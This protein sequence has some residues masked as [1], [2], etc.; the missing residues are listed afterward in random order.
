M[1]ILA[2]LLSLFSILYTRCTA[3]KVVRCCRARS[4]ALVVSFVSQIDKVTASQ[5]IVPSSSMPICGV[6]YLTY[7]RPVMSRNSH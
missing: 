4:G 3:R 1:T 5:A 6:T 7:I 2:L